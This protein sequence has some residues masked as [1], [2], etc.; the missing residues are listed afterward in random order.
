MF[1]LKDLKFSEF[2]TILIIQI[3]MK[4]MENNYRKFA[5]LKN[6]LLR[7]KQKK[8]QQFFL[9]LKLQILQN[10]LKSVNLELKKL[11]AVDGLTGL[12][13]YEKFKEFLFYEWERHKRNSTPISIM[14]IDID[15]FNQYN[16]KY[17]YQAGDECLK[18]IA[19]IITN[20]LKRPGDL[21][22][23]FGGEEFVVVLSE[24]YLSGAQ[25]IAEK[26]RQETEKLLILHEYSHVADHITVSIGCSCTVPK[27]GSD[28]EQLIKQADDALLQSK[29]SGKNQ[30]S[31]IY[32]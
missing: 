13:T 8:R 27:I 21:P 19:D 14:L 1:L 25:F 15:Y 22:A 24:T 26:I 29:R 17:G 28:S 11:A 23:R 16:E 2:A 10:K 5:K 4:L 18:K 3:E 12:F 9:N 7:D 31:E 32:I 6:K 20:A 30:V